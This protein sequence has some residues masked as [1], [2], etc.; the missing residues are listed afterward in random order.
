MNRAACLALLILSACDVGE[1]DVAELAISDH[2]A[3]KDPC[4]DPEI[5]RRVNVHADKNDPH[6]FVGTNGPDVIFGTEG[7]D[8]IFGNGGDDVICALGGDDYIDGGDGKDSID[9]GA[10]ND[11]VH[12]RGGSDHIWGG[13]GNDIL[14]GD[15]LDDHLFGEGGDDILIGGHGTDFMDGGDG[16]DFLRGDT[17][18]D[19]FI[20][21]DGN[22][23]A[24]FA[25]ALPP[26]QVEVKADGTP[27]LI[28]GVDIKLDGGCNS[29]GCANGDGGQEDLH[30]IENFVG[31]SFVD[32]FDAPGKNVRAGTGKPALSVFIDTALDPSGRIVDLGVVVLGGPGNDNLQI[33]GSD[34]NV[35][36]IGAGLTAGEGCAAID[37][38]SIRCDIGAYLA[39]HA[40]RDSPWHFVLA[41]GDAGDDGI[42]LFGN[43]PRE[44][45]AHVSGGTGNDHLIGGPEADVLFTGPDGSD[46]LEGGDGDDALISE[47]HHI[48]KDWENDDR[49]EVSKYHD[50]PDRLDAG[51]GNDQLV[52]DYVCGGHR[53][54]G[55]P[56]HDIAGFARSGKHGIWAQ[57]GG[58]T[59]AHE[60]TQ[61]YGYAA[62]MDLCGNQKSAWTSWKTGADADLEVLEASDGPD[63]LWG[64]D[65]ND[66][67]WGR[68]GGDHIWG[69]GG[70]DTILGAD[71]RDVIDGGDG[72]NHISYGSQST[73]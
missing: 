24:S 45:E 13:A 41:Y 61:W 20:G 16:N 1:V 30:G 31:S 73:M 3:G 17:G 51:P 39:T 69:L 37:A 19:T 71:G 67:I 33:Y 18:T 42:Q 35:K 60:Q 27:S 44:L 29:E 43:F 21:G 28:T 10:G 38:A 47:S 46:W 50:G 68:G 62:N 22:D 55:G 23:T 54:I 8:V 5:R 26:G 66:T 57:L 32:S 56:G 4:K 52:A 64:S 40:H 48:G 72:D 2:A 53:Y 25:T 14:F 65:E 49:P 9:A 34:G 12:G 59:A 70:D 15:V 36:V 11:I 63:H 7:N 6:K 58:K